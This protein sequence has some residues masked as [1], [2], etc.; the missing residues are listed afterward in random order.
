[1]DESMKMSSD[2][3]PHIMRKLI[4]RN[5]NEPLYPRN[6]KEPLI[7]SAVLFLLGDDCRGNSPEPCVVLNKRSRMVKQPGDLCFPGGRIALRLDAWLSRFLRLPLTPLTRWPYWSQW[8][9]RKRH[10]AGSLEL[11]LATSLRESL[12]EMRL[13]PFGV[14]FL[15]PLPPQELR[16][17]HRVIY[18][19]VAWV[20]RQR[21]F[22]LNWEVERIVYVPIAD[23]LNPDAYARYRLRY[24]TDFRHPM[25]AKTQDYPCFIHPT[26]EGPE[27]LW[28]AT[29]RIVMDF[30]DILSGFAPPPMDSLP[31]VR[32]VLD[33]E[34]LRGSEGA[35]P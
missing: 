29:Y 5:W 16:I 18:P 13:N 35:N 10:E 2:L 31:L 32:G 25:H 28:G 21:R 12:E 9:S 22:F 19:M 14:R 27:I 26:E 4:E 17:F 8:R 24:E 6:A 20:K 3:I 11:L 33:R 34:Y 30:L 15:G 1:M 7:A 23:L